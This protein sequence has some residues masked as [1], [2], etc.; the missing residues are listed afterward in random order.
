[1][2]NVTKKKWSLDATEEAEILATLKKMEADIV[3]NTE[4]KYH[5]NSEKYP[6]NEISFSETHMAYLKRY[7]AINPDQYISNLKLSTKL[8]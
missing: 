5:N 1:M 8:R 2:S 7:P 3:Y 4:S 6:D